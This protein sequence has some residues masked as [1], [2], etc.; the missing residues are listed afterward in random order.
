MVL[1]GPGRQLNLDLLT[2]T[3]HLWDLTANDL[4]RKIA[5]SEVSSLEVIDDHLGRI[6]EVNGWLN[7]VTRVLAEEARVAAKEADKTVAAGD[8]IGP[9]HGVPCTIKENIDVAGTPTTQGLPV[10]ANLIAPT[11]APLVERL[12]K[13]GAIPIGRTNLPELGLRVSTDNPLHGLTRNPWHPDRTAGGSSGGEGSAIA[14][15]MSPLGLGNDIGGSVRNPAFCCGITA[16][17]P[18]HGRLP[19][20]SV[21]EH[22]QNPALSSQIM[23]T[24]GPMA[25]SVSDLQTAI[26]ILN[27]RDPRDPRSVDVPLDG[28]DVK[29]RA[30][31]VK[32]ILG[33]ECH[34]S[35]VEGVERAA[36]S[37]ADAGWEIV[38]NTPPGIDLCSEIWAHL[39]G[40]DVSLLMNAAR[41]ILSEEMAAALDSDITEQFPSEIIDP[42]LI[43]SERI[44]LAREW[45]VFFTEHP[46]IIMPTWPQQPFEHGADISEDSR[47]E[48]IEILR[49]ITPANVLGLP[50]VALPVGVSEGLP[51]GVQC[52]ADRWR[53]DLALTAGSDIESSLGVITP[54]DPITS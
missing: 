26:K 32:S 54:I 41:P 48:L 31:V 27:G 44:R 36:S 42:N 5:D 33:T 30:A 1:H 20:F 50:S 7:A 6:E 11:D 18:T 38:E 13:A 51:Q 14:S 22:D 45:S 4:A 43:H 52:I 8:E 12:R 37:L 15:G 24:D 28:P 34:P 16:L 10:F 53:D 23:L 49:F 17:K 3:K 39:L 25:R 9:L 35:V 2:M 46:V 21:F 47:S 29:R 40:A 19:A